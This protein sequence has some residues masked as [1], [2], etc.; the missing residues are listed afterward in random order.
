MSENSSYYIAENGTMVWKNSIGQIHNEDGP[1]IERADGS[2]A[3]FINGELQRIGGPAIELSNGECF[4]FLPKKERVKNN[5]DFGEKMHTREEYFD[6][7]SEEDKIK[8]IFSY[9]FFKS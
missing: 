4:W 1:A 5:F 8:C 9:D 3:W 7:L 2:K 6:R